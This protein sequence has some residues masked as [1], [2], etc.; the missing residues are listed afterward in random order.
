MFYNLDMFYS[1]THIKIFTAVELYWKYL[2]TYQTFIN[3]TYN[4]FNYKRNILYE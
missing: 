3:Q 2:C 4:K 1:E